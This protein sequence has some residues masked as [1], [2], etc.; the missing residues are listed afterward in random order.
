[1]ENE[2][3]ST[4]VVVLLVV[5]VFSVLG[6][7]VMG[8]VVNENKRVHA[9][10]S[11]VQARY[12]AENG[13]TYFET[14]FKIFI[15]SANLNV[16]KHS[17]I[18][19]ILKVNFLNRYQNYVSVGESPDETK[20]KA[21]IIK[22]NGG[23][24]D[25]IKVTS[26]GKANSTEKKLI[27]YYK[28]DF[29]VDFIGPTN[30]IADFSG[31]GKAIDFSNT[32]LASLNLLNLLD[33]DLVK[34]AGSDHDFYP[35]PTE[36]VLS[37]KLL[38]NFLNVGFGNKPFETM[39]KYRVIATTES[40]LLNGSL[41]NNVVSIS[42]NNYPNVDDTNVLI[43]GLVNS[44]TVAGTPYSKGYQDINFK[45]LA[46]M[47][48]AVIQQDRPH[49]TAAP[50]GFSFN[51][52]LFVNKSL[53]IGRSSGGIG[54]LW[55]QG[56]MVAMGNLWIKDVDLLMGEKNNDKAIYVHGDVVIEN[57]CINEV[58][59]SYEFRLFAKG[60]ITIKSNPHCQKNNVVLYAEKG[61]HI[62]TNNQD[63]TIKGG[64]MGNI[65][66]DNPNK[67]KFIED[68][69]YLDNVNLS[70]KLTRKGRTF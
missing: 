23:K 43:N 3:G 40:T 10:E 54:N 68:P 28:V 37:V 51:E 30:K 49:D 62:I 4:L 69:Q 2:R 25:V 46:V 29:F 38:G 50:R 18:S 11:H 59:D 58:P 66:V 36:D 6:M 44:F 1:M 53:V 15:V 67:L 60:K 63:I 45:K 33:V 9:T 26:I 57:A 31:G 12:L 48:N 13:L 32:G 41:V 70:F 5:L 24:E 8:N 39:E 47:G 7:A 35:V 22:E 17:D 61:I 21:E 20:I 64:L 19:T 56:D 27:G 16:K 34:P 55:L 52:G 14:D 42:V 65:S